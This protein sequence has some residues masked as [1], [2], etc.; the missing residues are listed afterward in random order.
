MGEFHNIGVIAGDLN[1]VTV[2][3]AAIKLS[4]AL[5]PVLKKP[6]KHS[7]LPYNADYF[8]KNNV[9]ELGVAEL[10]HLKEFDQLFLGAIGDPTKV[11]P[12]VVELG[13]LLKVRQAFDQYVNLR[14][15]ILPE[16]VASVLVGKSS[17]DINFEI[18]RENSEGLY[19]DAGWIEKKDTPEEAGFQIMKCTYKGVK[20]LAEFAVKRAIA[21]KKGQKPLIHF[22]FKNNVLTYAASPWNRVFA[23]FSE[24]KDIETRYMHVDNFGMQMLVKP[25]QFDVVITENMFG[26]IMTD[27]G[28]ILQGGIGS[29]VSG[30]INPTGEFPSMFEPIHGSAPDKWYDL[31]EK[32]N[33]IPETFNA[34]K[35]QQIRPEAAF[36]AY[37][38]MLEQMHEEKAA[39]LMN[40]AGLANI[41]DPKYK[42][43][44]LDELTE[45]A[46]E[47]CKQK[48]KA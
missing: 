47:F 29:A 3:N 7:M 16:G 38:M 27:I 25:E 46:C 5:K 22:V 1:G 43:K 4:E 35:V 37:A 26:D 45:Q 21:R 30:N 23:E 32:G 14:P 6:I 8:V 24:R 11:K 34:K 40:Q 10:K 33:Y 44:T 17:K 48:V 12:G 19:V 9:K 41:R 13:I 31:D 2:T 36:F 28:A 15:V 42:E 39:E 18:C 20:R